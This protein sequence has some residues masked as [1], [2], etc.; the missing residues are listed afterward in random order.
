MQ[1]AYIETE[2]KKKDAEAYAQDVVPRAHAEADAAVQAARADAAAAL[3]RAAGD[4]D[5]FLALEREYRANPVV[6]RERL[7]RDAVEKAIGSARE[8]RWVPPPAGGRY[9]GVRLQVDVEKAGVARARRRP[10]R[11]ND[12][13]LPPPHGLLGRR[14]LAAAGS[15]LRRGAPPHQQRASGPGSRGS[16]C[17][18]SGR[19]S[20]RLA[21]DQWQIGE[22]LRGLAA[23]VVGTPILASGVRGIVTATRVAPPT[24][25][26]RSRCWL[27]RRAADFVTA[28]LIPLFLEVGRLF[29]ERSSLGARAAIDGDPRAGGAS[30]G[31][32]GATASRS[33]STPPA[34]RR[35]TRSW[36]G[37]ASGSRWTARCSSV[38][39]RWISRR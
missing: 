35:A 28:T 24:S 21:P 7:Y 26:W 39:R 20:L 30:G 32:R 33:A 17:S 27:R 10:R 37:R 16:R 9:Q 6:V 18:G 8:V 1:S 38:G 23:L 14:E 2:T 29:E 13:E 5:A 34:W 3:A 25:S 36:S 15:A 22:L 11:R 19:C 31:A 12:R 4:A